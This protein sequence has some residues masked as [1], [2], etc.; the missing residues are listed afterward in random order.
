MGQLVDIDKVAEG[1]FYKGGWFPE[2]DL[3]S[4]V[5]NLVPRTDE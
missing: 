1:A 5:I 4:D 2:G 3:P